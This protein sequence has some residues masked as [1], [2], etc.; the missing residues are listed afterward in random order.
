MLPIQ[1]FQGLLSIFRKN[2]QTLPAD[3][4]LPGKISNNYLFSV[5]LRH[6]DIAGLSPDSDATQTDTT[7]LSQQPGENSTSGSLPVSLPGL[8]YLFLN[9]LALSL[10]QS[11]AFVLFSMTHPASG[12]FDYRKHLTNTCD[13]N[14]WWSCRI[15]FCIH[16]SFS[17]LSKQVYQIDFLLFLRI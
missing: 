10:G 11:K 1:T 14:E 15:Y 3:K 4:A 13:M 5:F 17:L 8:A 9:I 16:S 2:S 12:G 7:A 6:I